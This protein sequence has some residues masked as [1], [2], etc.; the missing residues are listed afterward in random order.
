M[1]NLEPATRVLAGLVTGVR[2]E[3]LPGPT[4]CA[5]RSL[6]DLL[7]HIDGLSLAF[8]LAA[9]KTPPEGGSPGPSADA[10]RLG[11]DWRT[12]IPARLAALADAW[13]DESSWAGMTEAGGVDL[14]GEV[15]GVVA[16]DEVVVHGWDVAVATG[17]TFTCDPE[18]LEATYD[19][20]RQSV[21]E[22]PDGTPGLFGPPVPVP[23]DAPLL[24][25]LIALTGRDPDWR[26]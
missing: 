5:G 16:L 23:D 3:Q 25:R 21:A 19:F 14:P 2:D 9:A 22:S 11:P 26:P 1:L 20:V 7:D 15:A 4:P 17:Q 10:S 18:L 6:G 12:R 8:T 13:K 24:D